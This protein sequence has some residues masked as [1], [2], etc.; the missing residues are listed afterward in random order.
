VATGPVTPRLMRLAGG[1]VDA[2]RAPL[3]NLQSEPLGF[4]P[5]RVIAATFTLNRA[6][7]ATPEKQD[8]FYEELEQKLRSIP[9]VSRFALSDS[10]PPAGGFRG[11]PFSNMKIAGHPPLAENG[12][13]VAFRLVTPGYLRALPSLRRF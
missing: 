8:Q 5:E 1:A 11:R 10:L 7:Y 4:N 12:G 6:H 13:M 3:W 2:A 9:G